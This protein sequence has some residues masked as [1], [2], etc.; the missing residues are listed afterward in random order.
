MPPTQRPGV[1]TILVVD[2]EPLVRATVVRLLSGWGFRVVEAETAEEAMAVL[3][4]FMGEQPQL[5]IVD[6]VLPGDNGIQLARRIREE[7]PRQP[8]LYMSGYPPE[9]IRA[10]GLRDDADEF[11]PK[12]FTAPQLIER[13][14]AAL[15]RGRTAA[16][17]RG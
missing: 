2:D 11:M 5:I 3:T 4:T 6:V 9:V 1:P 12:P 10:Q 13:V 14:E 17:S 15:A 7:F 16:D 8:I